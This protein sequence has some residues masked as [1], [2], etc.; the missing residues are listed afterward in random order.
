MVRQTKVMSQA[1]IVDSM[2]ETIE[3]IK[4]MTRGNH[5]LPLI[6]DD[7]PFVNDIMERWGDRKYPEGSG[8]YGNRR[9]A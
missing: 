1:D 7:D 3:E 4:A 5:I 8:F 6:E 9:T 2:I